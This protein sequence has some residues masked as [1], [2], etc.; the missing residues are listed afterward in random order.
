MSCVALLM[1]VYGTSLSVQCNFT[2]NVVIR[3]VLY[4]SDFNPGIA[5]FE[6]KPGHKTLFNR[7]RS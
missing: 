6:S 5:S 4:K 2:P 7:D 3:F 1:S